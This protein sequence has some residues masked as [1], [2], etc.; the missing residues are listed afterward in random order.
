MFSLYPWKASSGPFSFQI[1]ATTNGDIY[2]GIITEIELFT[3][4][5]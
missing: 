1:K 2:T 4:N 3:R 5:I